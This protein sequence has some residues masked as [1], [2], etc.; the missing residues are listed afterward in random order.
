M[1]V[2][3]S[4]KSPEGLPYLN[5]SH[6]HTVSHQQVLEQN[7]LSQVHRVLKCYYVCSM[8]F[9]ALRGVLDL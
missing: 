4:D 2:L 7:T 6:H 8:L 9:K 5:D 3:K 1:D